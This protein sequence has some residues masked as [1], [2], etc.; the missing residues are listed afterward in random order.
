MMLCE[1]A[2]A[3]AVPW[4]GGL[5]AAALLREPSAPPAARL[6]AILLALFALQAALKFASTYVL[7]TAADR[8]AAD[9]RVRLYEHLQ[10]LPVA[11]YH[12]RR[13]GDT[14]AL[15][16]NDV[17][18]ISAFIGGTAVAFVPM[19]LT[20]VGAVVLMFGLRADLALLAAV[21][22]PVFFLMMKVAGRRI[23]P[24]SL[25][26]SNAEAEAIAVAHENLGLLPAIKTFTRELYEAQRYRAQ[27]DRVLEL[28]ARQRR[29]YAG[30]GPLM[31]FLAAAAILL[32]LAVAG[33]AFG[34]P[35]GAASLVGLLLYAH[36]LTRPVAG[37]ADFYGRTSVVL[38]AL[39]RVREAMQEP[40]E[41]RA[42]ARPLPRVRGDIEF[43]GVRFAYPDRAP[44]LD[45]LDLHIRAGETVGIVGPNGA[46]KSTLAHLLSRLHDPQEGCVLVDGI[47]IAGVAL[48]SLRRQVGVVPQHLLLFN[49]SVRHN[50]GYGRPDADPAAI[51]A[52]A[53]AAQ[54]HEFIMRLPDGYDTQVGDRGVRLSGGEQQRL[55]LARALLK[56]PP[57]LIL[58][59]AT[60]MF[61]PE[62]E[63]DFLR[64]CGAAF[65]GRTVILITHRMASLA[66]ASRV[67]RLEGGRVVGGE[68]RAC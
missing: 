19:V 54:A 58:D 25:G 18:E 63:A 21:L 50:I 61:D 64:A 35:L 37:L 20:A 55:A 68:T 17:D 46:G 1:G 48:E 7:E 16:T 4:A 32:V 27:V 5:L 47:D 13:L 31:Q 24:L 33:E 38:G 26:I 28:S 10:A 11:F 22:V 8:I 34:P 30:V 12:R 2:A 40:P 49:A 51:E 42:D 3:L 62:G 57:I 67:V 44:A 45:G 29:L 14:L 39:H 6:L 56:D 15:L 59:E 23:R 66:A 60:A 43:R 65:R 9:L 41:P 53:R 52:A 36:L